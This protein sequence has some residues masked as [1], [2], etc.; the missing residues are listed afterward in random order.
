MSV[1]GDDEPIPMMEREVIQRVVREPDA[2]RK[3][4][5]YFEYIA[6]NAPNVVPVQ[7]L[8]YHVAVA[9]GTD[10]D[11]PRNLAKSVTVE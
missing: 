11:Q 6:R 10:V 7:L 1:A 2:A 9:K 8:A 5:M 3:I 4:V